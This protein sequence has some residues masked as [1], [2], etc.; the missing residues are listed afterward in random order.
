MYETLIDRLT[1]AGYEHYELS[2][3]ARPGFHS[4]HNSSYWDGTPYIG[5][6]AAAHSYDIETR[7]WNTADIRQYIQGMADGKRIYE[8]ERLDDDTRYN[9]TITTA[10]RT[11]KGLDLKALSQ[12]HYEYCMK[13]A[14]RYLDNHLLE[15]TTEQR[16][17]LTREGLFVSDMVMSDLIFIA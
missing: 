10:L 9:D 6:G 17:R 7:S 13:N 2:N 5:I 11:S 4:R 15:L 3:F 8:E 1:A 12:K 14:Q 16:L